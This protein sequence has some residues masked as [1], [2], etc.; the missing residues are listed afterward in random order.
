M[1]SS[2]L[3]IA[4]HL[5]RNALWGGILVPALLAVAPFLR[6]TH[7]LLFFILWTALLVCGLLAL[8]TSAHLLLDAALFKLIA[9]TPDERKALEEV[10]T[11]LSRAGLRALAETTRSLPERIAGSLRL[12]NRQRLVLCVCVVLFLALALL[13]GTILHG[14]RF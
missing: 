1:T 10:D 14:G 4:G 13:P 9:A 5:R 8:V 3:E 11:V 2:P 12:V 6:E 7:D